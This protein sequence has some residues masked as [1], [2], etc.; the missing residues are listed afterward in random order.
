[1][2]RRVRVRGSNL[3]EA[4]DLMIEHAKSVIVI[5]GGNAPLTP[6]GVTGAEKWGICLAIVQLG[7]H[8]ISVARQIM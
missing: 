3:V 7:R 2:L 1:M 6:R 4:L 5:I 8:V